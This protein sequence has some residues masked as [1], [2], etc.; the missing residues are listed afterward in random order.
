MIEITPDMTPE[1]VSRAG[2]AIPYD[3]AKRINDE[4]RADVDKQRKKLMPELANARA[5]ACYGD[6]WSKAQ[7]RPVG[8]AELQLGI[9]SG[10]VDL[11]VGSVFDT[12]LTARVI[13]NTP[14]N[15]D[16]IQAQQLQQMFA[17]PLAVDP[18]RPQWLREL[19]GELKTHELDSYR[20]QL[21]IRQKA[22]EAFRR[23]LVDR[24]GVIK[25]SHYNRAKNQHE[26]EV[27]VYGDDYIA[28]LG[29]DYT[30]S[31]WHVHDKSMEKADF[32]REY[33]WILERYAGSET[34]GTPGW[35][36]KVNKALERFYRRQDSATYLKKARELEKP[37]IRIREIWY[38]MPEGRPGA[39]QF[40]G[41]WIVMT[42]FEDEIM[43]V[44]PAPYLD[45]R[46]P[47]HIV[48]PLPAEDSWQGRSWSYTNHD[49]VM[50]MNQ[51]A[52]MAL[53]NLIDSCNNYR[54]WNPSALTEESVEQITK[55]TIGVKD[56][57]LRAAKTWDMAV[58]ELAPQQISPS[59]AAVHAMM[60]G[61]VYSAT[62]VNL[63]RD[64][65][66]D[67]EGNTV[68][69][70]VSMGP[71]LG[72][73]MDYVKEQH[74]SLFYCLCVRGTQ[75]SA[76][77]QP[78]TLSGDVTISIM[79]NPQ[80]FWNIY[81]DRFYDALTIQVSETEPLPASPKERRE[82]MQGRLD[83]ASLLVERTGMDMDAAVA[84]TKPEGYSVMARDLKRK[85]LEAE[86]NPDRPLTPAQ[87]E[88]A[89]IL[90]TEKA[91]SIAQVWQH[92]YQTEL[93]QPA[94][95]QLLATGQL[96]TS[97]EAAV[98]GQPFGNQPAPQMNLAA[99]APMNQQPTPPLGGNAP[100]LVN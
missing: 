70:D 61:L 14:P 48:V 86:Q 56:L 26:V 83:L 3:E 35:W 78:F 93:A 59:I 40:P 65:T 76:G 52:S 4:I 39:E 30:K 54:L 55:K 50:A 73:M 1:Q 87:E 47:F 33:P 53:L 28:Q 100:Q 90:E 10:L 57:V 80:M 2:F 99:P 22:R 27:L 15:I 46:H 91:K 60:Q 7:E 58:K 9:A 13:A 98:G 29:R 21:K 96:R 31:A 6:E 88:K 43:R 37:T 18:R 23:A 44:D 74:E 89:A 84:V 82:D 95:Q 24:C 25:D 17:L 66:T 16:E 75:F 32:A 42:V 64:K 34:A 36:A 12:E 51:T 11:V 5:F 69:G 8:G 67:A 79:M 81:G 77:P 20:R 72:L 41:G 38:Q 45:G 63:R 85:R 49:G 92:F 71:Q 97:L 19:M 62:G 68:G 94:V